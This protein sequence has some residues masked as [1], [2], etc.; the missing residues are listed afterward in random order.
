MLKKVSS[1]IL[2]TAS[3]LV[4]SACSFLYRP[5]IQQGNILDTQTIAQLKPGMS[6]DQVRYMMGTPVLQNNFNPNQ[7]IYV[8]TFKPGN[9]PR[10]EQR[11]ILNFNNGI[12]RNIQ[13]TPLYTVP[14]T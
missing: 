4:I 10:Q 3:C 1:F 5:T 9:K 6:A 14:N 11:V 2:I 7:W 13:T 12:L 8:Y